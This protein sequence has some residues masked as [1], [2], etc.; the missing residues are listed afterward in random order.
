[1]TEREFDLDKFWWTVFVVR[2]HA[3]CFE[4]DDLHCAD[5]DIYAEFDVVNVS[6]G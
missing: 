4:I 2:V 6:A 1:M 5:D 3:F